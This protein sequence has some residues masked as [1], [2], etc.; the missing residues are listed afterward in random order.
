MKLLL[1]YLLKHANIKVLA[2]RS[3]SLFK[4]FMKILYQPSLA[5]PTMKAKKNKED[6]EKILEM[7][8]TKIKAKIH[9]LTLFD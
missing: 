8:L 1:E 6:I 2:L 3:Y 9:S 4:I 7:A 5:L